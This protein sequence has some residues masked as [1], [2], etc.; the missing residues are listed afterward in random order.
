MASWTDIRAAIAAKCDA[1]PGIREGTSTSLSGVSV[2]PCVKVTHVG[3]VRMTDR[4]AGYERR[5]ANIRGHL[6]IAR[7][8]DVGRAIDDVETY[9]EAITVAFRDGYKLGQATII[10]DCFLASWEAGS[11]EYAGVDYAG[12]SLTWEVR[13]RENISRSV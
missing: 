11:Y 5:T 9:A 13:V 4:G 3:D 8:A 12:A 1:V 7:T 2:T 10:E 6:L